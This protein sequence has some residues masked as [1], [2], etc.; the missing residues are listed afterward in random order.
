MAA[1]PESEGQAKEGPRDEGKGCWVLSPQ[2]P[3]LMSGGLLEA[4]AQGSRV[5][6]ASGTQ[7][8]PRSGVLVV[9]GRVGCTAF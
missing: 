1:R 2:W 5:Q 4:M 6:E 7:G 8:R 9:L 3:P